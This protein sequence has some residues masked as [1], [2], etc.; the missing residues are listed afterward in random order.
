M[1]HITGNYNI[2]DSISFETTL[3][4]IHDQ[5]T[6]LV[7]E[8]LKHSL[9]TH[10][11][12]LIALKLGFVGSLIYITV[13]M[14]IQTLWL[15]KRQTFKKLQRIINSTS[16]IWP[17]VLRHRE[18]NSKCSYNLINSNLS[19]SVTFLLVKSNWLTR[20]EYATLQNVPINQLM[21]RFLIFL[22]EVYALFS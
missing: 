10:K 3:Q 13:S 21:I 22:L 2:L 7:T 14:V 19:Y 4:L 16:T 8:D 5:I 9:N 15:L 20:F 1:T 18:C 6:F 12:W 17:L 11:D